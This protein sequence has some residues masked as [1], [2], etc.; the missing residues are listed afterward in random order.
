M[1]GEFL[2]GVG[3][4]ATLIFLLFEVRG[5]TKILKANASTEITNACH[6]PFFGEKRA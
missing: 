4:L 5:N 6:G 1:V 3:V 2:G